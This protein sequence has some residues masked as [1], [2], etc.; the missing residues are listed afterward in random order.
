MWVYWCFLR[1]KFDNYAR[2]VYFCNVKSEKGKVYTRQNN[3]KHYK[4][5]NPCTSNELRLSILSRVEPIE[6]LIIFGV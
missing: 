6:K 4:N 1:V 3:P 5:V 2:I